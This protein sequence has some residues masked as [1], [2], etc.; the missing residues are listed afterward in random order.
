IIVICFA[1]VT[2]VNYLFKTLC[3]FCVILGTDLKGFMKQGDR[4]GRFI[5]KKD[6]KKPLSCEL[7]GCDYLWIF[8]EKL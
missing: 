3:V 7:K 2:L 1:I 6:R 4:R 5:D 8:S